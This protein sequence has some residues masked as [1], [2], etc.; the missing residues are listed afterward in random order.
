MIHHSLDF[1]YFFKHIWDSLL[2]LWQL[3]PKSMLPGEFFFISSVK[4]PYSC[5]FACFITFCWKLDIEYYN[6]ENLAMFSPSSR[7]TV[8]FVAVASLFNDFFWILWSLTFSAMYDYWSLHSIS[9]L[10]SQWLKR[11]LLKGLES[12][13]FSQSLHVCC[14]WGHAFHTQPG[15]LQHC[16]SL[17]FL[18]MQSLRVSQRWELRNLVGL[19]WACVQPWAHVLF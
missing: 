13:N 2:C 11:D 16:L 1:P 12:K 5:F 17:Y 8:T 9:L 10:V 7:F 19:P 18:L 6:I 15:S 4:G 14:V 3:S